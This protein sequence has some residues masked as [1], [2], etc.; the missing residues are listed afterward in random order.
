MLPY[1]EEIELFY[2]EELFFAELAVNLDSIFK[3]KDKEEYL[4]MLSSLGEEDI[5]KNIIRSI[6]MGFENASYSEEI[7]ERIEDL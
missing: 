1:E 4:D 7:E 5:I 3:C 2:T 6:M